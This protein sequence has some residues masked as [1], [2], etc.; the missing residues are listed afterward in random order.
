MV[1]GR[2]RRDKIRQDLVPDNL[3]LLLKHEIGNMLGSRRE[4]S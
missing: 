3:P 2:S 4:G 1:A